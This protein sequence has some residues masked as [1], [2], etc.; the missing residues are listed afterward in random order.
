[1][2]WQRSLSVS[3]SSF[4]DMITTSLVVVI[5]A[6]NIKHFIQACFRDFRSYSFFPY[7]KKFNW[8]S[9]NVRR[10]LF[11]S[12]SLVVVARMLNVITP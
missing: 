9:Y 7:Q 12:L 5:G 2:V 4:A 1:M 10:I 8:V 11:I 3:V 6:A